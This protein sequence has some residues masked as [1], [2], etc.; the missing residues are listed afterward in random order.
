MVDMI[1]LFVKEQ[2]GD[3][4]IEFLCW[5]F[6]VWVKII[7]VFRMFLQ[8]VLYWQWF[9]V[10]GEYFI[11]CGYVFIKDDVY[12]LMC[13]KFFGYEI[14]IV[15]QIEIIKLCSIIELD[16]GEMIDY[17]MQIDNWCVDYGCLLFK[18]EDSEYQQI[19]W[20]MGE[21]V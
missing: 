16:K 5:D 9:I 19:M 1:I 6:L 8:N 13:Y 14:K 20:E 18:F 12:D 17:M 11:E 15:G 4:M 10:M 21:V 7:K 2:F 3:L